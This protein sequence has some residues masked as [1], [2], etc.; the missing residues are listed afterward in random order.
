MNTSPVHV[1]SAHA[2][3]PDQLARLQSV[4]PRLVIRQ[5]QVASS[6]ELTRLVPPE[7]EILLSR[8]SPTSLDALPALRWVQTRG[9]GVNTLVGSPLWNAADLTITTA[10][11]VAAVPIAEHVLGMMIALARDFLGLLDHQRQARWPAIN[12]RRFPGYAF[13]GR[14]IVIVGYGSIGREIARI[15]RAFGLHVIA[16]KRDPSARRDTGFVFPGTGDPEG[17][18]PDRIISPAQLADVLPLASFVVVTCASTP[19][20]RHLVGAPELE[21]LPPEAFLLNVSRGDTIDERALVDALQSRRIAGAALD[22]FGTEPLPA[23]HPL[24][25][26]DNVILSPHIAGFSPD[27][28][29]RVVELFAANLQRYL[30]GQPLFNQVDRSLGY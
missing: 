6:A 8:L 3:A 18:L 16:V 15:T 13:R 12:F 7:T 1:F 22:V 17:V 2:F 20:T 26:L 24:W 29:D 28:D 25:S 11:G 27:Y 14:T 5:A 10:S 9:A 23:D 21:L 30:A 19:A 4:S